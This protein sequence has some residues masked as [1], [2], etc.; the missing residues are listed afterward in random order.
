[1]GVAIFAPGTSP[2]LERMWPYYS[3]SF[4]NRGDLAPTRDPNPA[5]VEESDS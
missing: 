3:P 4:R 5:T 1:M 2:N